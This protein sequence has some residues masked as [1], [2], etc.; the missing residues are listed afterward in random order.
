MPDIED[1]RRMT[2]PPDERDE[3]LG[4]STEEVP[5]H[6]PGM[7]EGEDEEAPHRQHPYPDPDKTPGRAEG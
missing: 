4:A 5:G 2:E 3:G 6:T 1:P 7:A